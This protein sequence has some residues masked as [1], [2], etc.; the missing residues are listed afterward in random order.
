MQRGGC[1]RGK[2]K[3]IEKSSVEIGSKNRE[4]KER[5]TCCSE[6]AG[7]WPNPNF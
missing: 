6:E 2:E 1:S 3:R 4:G 7:G 5:D